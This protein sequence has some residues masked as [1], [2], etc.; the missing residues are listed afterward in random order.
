MYFLRFIII[1]LI[2]LSPIDANA[3]GGSG[4]FSCT[5]GGVINLTGAQSYLNRANCERCR[6]ASPPNLANSDCTGTQPKSCASTITKF[7]QAE[8]CR[9]CYDS[10][11][12]FQLPG[13][14][15]ASCGG[16]R[17]PVCT[18]FGDSG[19]TQIKPCLQCYKNNANKGRKATLKACDRACYAEAGGGPIKFITTTVNNAKTVTTTITKI[20][21]QE[22]GSQVTTIS[23]KTVDKKSVKNPVPDG[24]KITTEIIPIIGPCPSNCTDPRT[25][26]E[27][28]CLLTADGPP[29][30]NPDK[31]ASR[32][33]PSVLCT[34][35]LLVGGCVQRPGDQ[36]ILIGKTLYVI[37]AAPCLAYYDDPIKGN[38][39]CT[40][41]HKTPITPG[42]VSIG[43][44]CGPARKSPCNVTDRKDTKGIAACKSCY[45]KG[46]NFTTC[47]GPNLGIK[48]PVKNSIESQ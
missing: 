30:S 37:G 22:D 12:S 24:T 31:D 13:K 43:N 26:L 44:I 15:I 41:C 32:L 20:V 34:P 9:K 42:L 36:N 3:G 2:I 28:R 10:P 8:D 11:N 25:G 5:A 1:T 14:S 27:A 7:S 38:K 6:A 39:A 40:K 17:T 19:G 35:D 23:H 48:K 33:P 29:P 46:G 21:T 16:I 18:A 45:T 47:G 4:A